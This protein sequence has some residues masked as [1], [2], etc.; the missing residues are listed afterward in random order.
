MSDSLSPRFVLVGEVALLTIIFRFFAESGSVFLTLFFSVFLFGAYIR[1]SHDYRHGHIFFLILFLFSYFLP[2]F[3]NLTVASIVFAISWFIFLG[4]QSFFLL[5]AFFWRY[6]LILAIFF[7]SL[8]GFLSQDFLLQH[9][10][11]PLVLSGVLFIFLLRTFFLS[12][13]TSSQFANLW[14][15]AI[16][17]V[18]F[19]LFFIM[20]FLPIAAFHT[21]LLLT[22]FFGVILDAA[23]RYHQ[24]NLKSQ[25]IFLTF[26]IPTTFFIFIF[27]TSRLTL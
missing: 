21:S 12:L 18:I 24:K 11:I 15:S 14:S 19:E 2:L 1:S 27:L 16:V 25:T 17:F 5:H 23:A 26:L 9:S 7:C 13:E 3:F 22:L 4:L 20:R 10:F 6:T 8:F